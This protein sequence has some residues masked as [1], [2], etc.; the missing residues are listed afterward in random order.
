MRREATGQVSGSVVESLP[1]MLEVLGS[2][3]KKERQRE[4]RE[5]GGRERKERRKEGR[6]KGRKERTRGG[7]REGKEKGRE[8]GKVRLLPNPDILT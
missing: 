6:K 8:G 4:K 1:G 3:P 7:R 5:G 2:I